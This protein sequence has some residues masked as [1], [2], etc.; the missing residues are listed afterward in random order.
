LLR[1]GADTLLRLT[2]RLLG[3]LR[4]ASV[5]IPAGLLDRLAGSLLDLLADPLGLLAG[6]GLGLLSEPV[7]LLPDPRLGGLPS[8]LLGLAPGLVGGHL[9][10]PLGLLL[11][12]PDAL[13]GVHLEPLGAPHPLFGLLADSLLLFGDALLL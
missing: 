6:A 4:N 2:S 8:L 1:L 13:C 7:G 12:L 5:G 11:G 9:D 3:G 10:Q